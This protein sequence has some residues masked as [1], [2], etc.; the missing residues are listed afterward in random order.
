ML[1]AA[2][3]AAARNCCFWLYRCRRPAADLYVAAAADFASIN[4][5]YLCSKNAAA[6]A[7]AFTA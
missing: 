7:A 2:Y 3:E 6:T 4:A 1:T 5:A